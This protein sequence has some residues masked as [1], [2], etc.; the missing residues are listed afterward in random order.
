M[1]R[2]ALFVLLLIVLG[3]IVSCENKVQGKEVADTADSADSSDS[4]DTSDTSDSAD[5]SDSADTANTGDTANSGDSSDSADTAKPTVVGSFNVAYTGDIVAAGET[6]DGGT[7][8]A[9]FAFN[10]D[11]FTYTDLDL[12]GYLHLPAATLNEDKITVRW[13]EPIKTGVTELRVLLTGCSKDA[14]EG[15]FAF[16]EYGG[17]A[18]Y[19]NMVLAEG[20]WQVDCVYAVSNPETSHMTITAKSDTNITFTAAGELIDPKIIEDKLTVPIC[21]VEE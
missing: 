16:S 15:R 11:N 8:D 7:G 13:Y 9:H 14:P 4:G 17:F 1:K 18:M 10:E 21:A 20:V 2:V 12:G 19:A 5:S 6:G 3:F